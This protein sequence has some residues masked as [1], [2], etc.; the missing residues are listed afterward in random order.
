MLLSLVVLNYLL[1]DCEDLGVRIPYEADGAICGER[2]LVVVAI[3][4][5]INAVVGCPGAIEGNL[6]LIV[7]GLERE[8]AAGPLAIV[9][10]GH[11]GGVAFG[12]PVCRAAGLGLVGNPS[13]LEAARR[14]T[15]FGV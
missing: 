9:A 11:L 4:L 2:E 6:D 5:A 14:S 13:S 3:G 8:W 12:L 7:T 15:S 10:L 1:I